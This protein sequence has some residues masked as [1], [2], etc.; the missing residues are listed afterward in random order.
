MDLI[1]PL[2]ASPTDTK[3][4]A[5]PL[6]RSSNVKQEQCGG[7]SSSCKVPEAADGPAI[8]DGVDEVMLV[9]AGDGVEQPVKRKSLVFL[10]PRAPGTSNVRS[11]SCCGAS[12][13]ASSTSR[14]GVG[15]GFSCPSSPMRKELEAMC[16]VEL[17]AKLRA[18]LS[19]GG[20][21]S[22]EKVGEF[23]NKNDGD[24]KID[25]SPERP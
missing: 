5:S 11:L 19:C 4:V 20:S 17:E 12:P 22:S 24:N 2:L 9:E 16:R 23:D 7:S 21:M 15:V 18:E 14:K 25:G 1:S 10:P 6:R 13:S 3:A 8:I